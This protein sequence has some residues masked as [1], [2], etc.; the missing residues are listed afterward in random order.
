MS[1]ITM[2]R[3]KYRDGN[4]K[5]LLPWWNKLCRKGTKQFGSVFTK[6]GG[7]LYWEFIFELHVLIV[8]LQRKKRSS[9]FIWPLQKVLLSQ[10]K[11]L[12]DVPEQILI[13]H[14]T[15]HM[16]HLG[17]VLYSTAKL[18]VSANGSTQNESWPHLSAD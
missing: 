4:N 15:L 13:H 14:E 6:R 16:S 11:F 18:L 5:T 8:N 12:E 9:Y 1:N 10:F 2:V 3:W 17:S 7:E